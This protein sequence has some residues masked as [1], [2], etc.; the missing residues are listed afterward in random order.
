MYFTDAYYVSPGAR[1]KGYAT[2]DELPK[3]LDALPGILPRLD[4]VERAICI[5]AGAADD[6]GDDDGQG[7]ADAAPDM[8]YSPANERDRV[9]GARE[10]QN[11]KNDGPNRR[12][13]GTG[14]SDASVPAPVTPVDINGKWKAW[15]RDNES[16]TGG[17]QSV[18]PNSK[19]AE[20]YVGGNQAGTI[21][22]NTSRTASTLNMGRTFGVTA[23]AIGP[24]HNAFG[25][26]TGNIAYVSSKWE[27]RR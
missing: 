3:K 8:D 27:A 22:G 18:E 25:V 5:M 11:A 12:A 13:D 23:D 17:S 16:T 1:A 2:W 4:A 19:R 9:A 10:F 7:A 15:R 14:D 20:S 24:G 6:P 26:T 21:S